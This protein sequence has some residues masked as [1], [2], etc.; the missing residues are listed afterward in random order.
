[1][2]ERER[3]VVMNGPGTAWVDPSG[4]LVI[5]LVRH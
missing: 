2:E 4:S 5:R 3:T 1:V